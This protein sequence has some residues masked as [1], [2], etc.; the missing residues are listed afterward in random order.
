MGIMGL[1]RWLSGKEAT[2]NAGDTSIIS[3]SGRS[4]GGGNDNPL[5]HSYLE[6]PKDRG[7]WWATAHKVAKSWTQLGDQTTTKGIII[8]Y[9][10]R[11]AALFAICYLLWEKRYRK[12]DFNLNKKHQSKRNDLKKAHNWEVNII[13]TNSDL[14]ALKYLNITKHRKFE[15]SLSSYPRGRGEQGNDFF[16]QG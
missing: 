1:P 13:L 16:S 10:K 9:A 8:I 14:C 11:K 4:H 12:Q 3:G 5:Q 15:N 6:N 7:A 2:C